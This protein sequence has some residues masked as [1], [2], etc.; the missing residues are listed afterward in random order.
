MSGGLHRIG[1]AAR[2]NSGKLIVLWLQIGLLAACSPRL[3]HPLPERPDVAFG[4]GRLWQIDGAG[5]EPSYVFAL[6][7]ARDER[8]SPLPQ[9]VTAALEATQVEA[10]DTERDP[11]T[12]EFFYDV[13]KLQLPEGETLYDLIGSRSYGILTWHMKR[14]QLRPK[15]NI[16]PW[17][18]WLSLGGA[19]WGFFDWDSYFDHKGLYELDVLMRSDAR[20]AGRKIVPLL[21]DKEAFDLYNEMP[22]PLQVA[23]L[24]QRLDTYSDETPDVPRVKLYLDGDLAMLDALWNEY[25]AMLPPDA[26]RALDERLIAA[27]NRVMVE[28]MVPLMEKGP[29]F[30][31]VG[32]LHLL[33]DGGVLDLLQRRGYTVT[34]LY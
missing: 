22:L 21:T 31:A 32:C 14:S 15:D 23:L 18:F 8:L 4:Q 3:P 27:P 30:V 5:V 1:A 6:L 12:A 13:E 19:N 7:R 28:R 10:F 26:A 16:K 25:L 20:R 2:R 29:T 17:A 33:G 11:L 34:R 24:K 9:A